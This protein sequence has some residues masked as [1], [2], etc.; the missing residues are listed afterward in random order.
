M[1]QSDQNIVLGEKLNSN[2]VYMFKLND[3]TDDNDFN[4][5]D[6]SLNP[7]EF[8]EKRR[9]SKRPYVYD[10]RSSEAYELENIPGS[11]NLPIEH[12]E[13]S[14][15]QMP[16]TGDILLYGGED[17]EVLTAAEI[18]YNN[19]FNSFCFTD[20][21]EALLSSVEDSYLSITDAAQKQIKDQLQ[22][23]DSL[24]GVQIIVDR[25]PS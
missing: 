12:F 14:I 15:Y 18:L 21:F 17:G 11:H 23:S 7:R 20:S 13:T 2:G 24:T 3:L 9:T 4:A 6:Y 1:R 8:F 10:L 16:F 22:N 25:P 19:G 5:S